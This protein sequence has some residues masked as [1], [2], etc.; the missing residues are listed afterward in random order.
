MLGKN[1]RNIVAYLNSSR[2]VALANTK[3]L[4]VK[5]P[6]TSCALATCVRQTGLSTPGDEN[7]RVFI[8]VANAK[9]N[10]SGNDGSRH[11]HA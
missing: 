6:G 4:E 8:L 2:P 7:R 10:N 11:Q 3:L 9:A 5:R 1:L